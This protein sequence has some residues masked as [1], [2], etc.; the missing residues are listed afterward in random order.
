MDDELANDYVLTD[1]GTMKNCWR[2]SIL[3]DHAS[4]S[5]ELES[6]PP[7]KGVE[8]NGMFHRWKLRDRE[9]SAGFLSSAVSEDVAAPDYL[10]HLLVIIN[11]K[12]IGDGLATPKVYFSRKYSSRKLQVQTDDG[13]GLEVTYRAPTVREALR[14][15]NVGGTLEYDPVDFIERLV[16][17]MKSNRPGWVATS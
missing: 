1:Y 3:G 16:E 15:L 17:V 2:I 10:K 13:W 12:V 14:R 8:S 5:R 7:L 4:T 9:I 6:S 11:D